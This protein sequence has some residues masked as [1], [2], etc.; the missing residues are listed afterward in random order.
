V[1]A[2]SSLLAVELR[3]SL[4]SRCCG[5]LFLELI[6][7]RKKVRLKNFISLV[8]VLLCALKANAA[9]QIVGI[10][11]V[12]GPIGTQVQISGSGFGSSQSTVA[13]NGVNAP[14]VNWSDTLI[15]ANVPAG[16]ITGPVKVTVAG[17]DSNVNVYFN[18]PPPVVSSISPTSGIVGTQ[19]MINGSGFQTTKGS[20]TVKF[21]GILG[22]VVS[23]SDSQIIATVPASASTGPVLVTVNTVGSNSDVLFTMPNPIITSLSP[24]SAP[25][26]TLVHINGTGFG[27]QTGNSVTFSPSTNASIITWSDTQIAATVPSTATTGAVMVTVG[28]VNTPANI[29][30]TV[31]PPQVNSVSPTVGIVGS[32]VTISGSGFQTSKGTS[33]VVL[34]NTTASTTSWSDTQIVATVPSGA[35]SGPAVITVNGVSSNRDVMFTVPNPIITSVSPSSG[36]VGT[37]VV[38]NGTGFGSAQGSTSVRF[39]IEFGSVAPGSWSDTQILTAVPQTASGGSIPVTVGNSSS[40]SPIDFNV[41]IPQITSISPISGSVG[42]HVTITGSGF[43]SA[44]TIGPLTSNISFTDRNSNYIGSAVVSWSDTQI[45]AIVPNGAVTGPVKVSGFSAAS[46]TDVVFSMANPIITSIS[47][48]AGPAGATVQI[49]G[50]GFGATQPAGSTVTFAQNNNAN[51]IVTWSDNQI[52]VKVPSTAISGGVKVT[53]GGVS[54]NSN[55][56][57]TVPAPHITSITPSSG[58]VGTQI[59]ITGSGFQDPQP[60]SSS[61]NFD[62]SASLTVNSW[63]DT[64][65]VATVPSGG[66]TNPLHVTVNGVDSN[67]DVF[68]TLPKPVITGIAPSGGPVGTLVHISG[69][70]FGA[71]QDTGSTVRLNINASVVTWSDTLITATIPTGASS[72]PMNVTVGGVVSSSNPTF[73]VSNVFVNAVSPNAGAVGTQ[74]TVSGS[75]FGSTLGTISFNNVAATVVAT[76]TD[77]QIIANVPTTATT[78]PVKVAAGGVTSN[79]SVGFTVGAVA[80]NSVSPASG[81]PGTPV[82]ISGSGFGATQG[83]STVKFSGQLASVTSWSDTAIN[84]NVSMSA[85]TGSVVVT[86]AGIASNSTVNFVVTPPV[87][88]AITPASGP[89]STP[90]QISGHGFG[91]AQGTSTLTI[92]SNGPPTNITWSDT[93]ITATVSATA[94]SGQAYITMGAAT[95]NILYFTVPAPQVISITPT[96]GIVNTQVTISGTGFQDTMGS[97]YVTFNGITATT[98]NANWSNTQIIANVPSSAITG[99][100]QVWVNNSTPSNQDVLFSMPNPV[101]VSVTPTSGPVDSPSPIHINGSGFGTTQGTSTIKM[102]SLPINVVTWSDTVIAAHIPT[103]GTGGPILITEGGVRSNTNINFNI[104]A[105]HITSISPTRGTVGTQV[106]VTG[107]GFGTTQVGNN[108]MGFYPGYAAS[109]V[110][111]SDTQIVG[112]VPSLASTGPL[113]V[114]ITGTYSNQEFEFTLIKPFITG[115]VPSRGP[116][117]SQFQ[118]NGSG[119]GSTQGGSTVNISGINADVVSWSDTQILATVPPTGRSGAVQVTVSGVAS[120]SNVSYTVPAPLITSI[121]PGSGGVG[122]TLTINGSGFQSAQGTGG[123]YFTGATPSATTLSWS[124]TQVM[125]SVPATS[126]TGSIKLVANNTQESNKDVIF[127]MPNPVIASL[128]PT[129]GTESTQVQVNGSGFG[130]TQGSSTI[131]FNAIAATVVSWSDTQILARI[132]STAGSGPVQVVEGGV[133]GN[134]NV[135]FTVPAPQISSISPN[136]GG[137]GNPITINGSGFHA[138]QGSNWV[139]FNGWLASV[140]SWSDTQ[141]VATVPP[142]SSTGPVKAWVNGAFSNLLPYTVPSLVINSLSPGVGPVGT[143]V[144][145]NGVAFGS[146]QGTSSLTFNGQAAASIVS[147]SDTQIVATVPV[148]AAS[149]PAVVTVNNVNS[150]ALHHFFVPPPSVSSLWPEGGIAGTQITITGSGF[151]ASQRN[152]TITFNGIPATATTWADTQIVATVPAGAS[153]GQ[154]IITVN[155][156]SSASNWSFEVPNPVITSI[157]PPEAPAGGTITIAGSGFG[158]SQ[159]ISAGG[160]IVYVGSISLNGG[161]VGAASWSDTSITVTLPSNATSGSLT[162][163]KYNATSNASPITVEGAPVIAALTPSTGPVNGSVVISG[164]NFGS[165]QYNSTV[166]FNGNLAT[167]TSWSNSQITAVV[168]PGTETGPAWVTIAGVN[169]PSQTFTVNTSAQ[170]TDSLGRSSSYTS[171][172]LGGSWL[173]SDSQGSGCSSCTVRGT[174]H[175]DYDPVGNLLATTDELL[176]KTDFTYDA[177]GNVVSQ[178]AH[179]DANTPVATSYTYNSFGEPLTVTDPLGNVTTNTYDANGN[180]L[181]VTSPKPDAPTAASVTQF[182]YDAKGQLTQITDPLSHITTLAYYPTGLIHTITDAQSNVTSY[183]YDL[184]GNRTAVVDVQQNRTTF[185]Y[186]LG[187]RLTGITYPD[188]TSVSFAYDGRGRRTSVTDQN[189]KVTSYAYDDA[190]RLT[191]VTDAAQHVT[192]Y[193]YDLE[194]NL[195][196]ITDAAQ[197][198]T[199]FIYDAF[200]RV[201]QTAFPSSL[202]ENYVYDAIGNLTSKIDRKNQTILYVYDTLNRLS[203]KGYPDATGVDYVYDLVGK[204]KQ[205]SDPTGTYGFSYDNMGRLIGTTTQYSFLP[206]ITYTN[207]Y[208]Y[209]AAS[210]RTSFT[211]PDGST[212]TYAYDTLNRLN[213]L[214]NSLTG[215]FGFGYDALSR[216]TAFNRPNGVN[217]SYSYDSLSRL[218]NV[219]HKA[220]T[221]TLDGAGYTYDNAGNRTAKTNYLNNITEQ[222]T[223]DP[224][225]QL[226]QVTQGTTTTESYSYDAVGNRLS[227]LGMSPYVYNSSNELTSTPSATFTYDGNGNTLTKTD[228]N[229]TTTYNWDFEN[230]LT[231]VVLPGTNGTVSFAYDPFGRRIQKNSSSATTNYLYDNSNTV[232][233]IGATGTLLAR[234]IQGTGV[235]EPMAELRGVTTGYYQQDGLGSVTSMTG[236]TGSQLNSDIYDSFGDL[237]ASTGSFGNPFQYTGRDF[238]RETGLQYYRARY[239]DSTIGRFISEDPA[240][241]GDDFYAYAND[242]PTNLVDPFGLNACAIPVPVPGGGGKVIPFP[243][244]DPKPAVSFCVRFPLLCAIGAIFIPMNS[245]ADPWIAHCYDMLDPSCPNQQDP[246]V[247]SGL[248]RRGSSDPIP[249]PGVSDP[250]R[251]PCKNGPGKCKPCPPDTPYW[252]Q[253]GNMHG[254]TLGWHTH[255]YHWNQDP[256]TCKCYPVR[257]SG[258]SQP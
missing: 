26:G 173:G 198:T 146:T 236:A 177:N 64:Q 100:V 76:W 137:V 57:F 132:P 94:K 134:A 195:T 53:Q 242:N 46:N 78:G 199:S 16:A 40:N 135:Y 214:T 220:G 222:Y 141:I 246:L 99:P 31:P 200:G 7:R 139:G 8:V 253:P 66:G 208:G 158:P 248:G 110:S 21:G 75:G 243:C 156:V 193:A 212:N 9:P 164:S 68:F 184:R 227:S 159:R 221:V 60:T 84:A 70:G 42:T 51:N 86:V 89:V 80:V 152:S 136:I 122:T 235:D 185:A 226:S 157:T 6:R 170:I 241:A 166:Q 12:S 15:T 225:Y 39:G 128:L 211:A 190:D 127:T 18:V 126:T 19:V 81:S 119:F 169:A 3:P 171:V 30:F 90:V 104:P 224:L 74:V 41:P 201:T 62:N 22:G 232:E 125:V 111:W 116:V 255:W 17:I 72:G 181:T 234:Y 163:T 54:S 32:S 63:H 87:I 56:V 203:H 247:P 95:S 85:S 109:I 50:S 233:E 160:G 52:N 97:S 205:V 178:T 107:S 1:P 149:G 147:W 244:P 123:V 172:M 35:T 47:P 145:I 179:L 36:P 231:A 191:S 23:W 13:F 161:D 67:R 187:N 150:D 124:D 4:I 49:N 240:Q 153:S 238:D 250:G 230:R 216:R 44:Q 196:S 61:I 167:V 151:Q 43:R 69:S 103:T 140:I 215:Q 186:D 130:A 210:N 168:P 175:N 101:V 183:E 133:K 197:H 114:W 245:G 82:Q 118:I 58:G 105:P 217:T 213:T 93:L 27:T 254:G 2:R 113:Y 154:V 143:Q 180:L 83:T 98:T 189:G 223:Y 204:I 218:L 155:S 120:N 24:A 209:D 106:T 92:G 257:M 251:E 121:S 256:K 112:T 129:S 219:L 165:A 96:S 29:I 79:T 91:T 188:T 174:I 34:N 252:K 28:G 108:V 176:H 37:P 131:T 117:G 48:S 249:Y 115:L 237:T 102:N 59:T 144:T 206:G 182:T 229:G 142:G 77:T 20:S 138:S 228:S 202:T 55:Q 71:T 14:I 148:T 33:T 5:L 38:I 25:V 258:G 10:S 207:A 65:I 11:P 162:V 88:T 192:T 239:Y 73:T 45:V 194:N